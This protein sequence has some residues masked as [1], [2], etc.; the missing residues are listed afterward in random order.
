MSIK[1]R[2]LVT[3]AAGHTGA[4]AVTDLLKKGFRVRAF[5]RREDARSERLRQAGAEIFVGDL[6]DMGDIRRSLVDVQRAYY[7][8]PFAPNLLHGTMLFALAAEEARLETLALMSEWNPHPSHPAP[9][10][11]EHWI[12]NNIVRWMPTVDVTYV[13]LYDIIQLPHQENSGGR[14]YA[15]KRLFALC[16]IGPARDD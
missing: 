9:L 14:V 3:S 12:A 10:T 8:P 15:G 7:V 6:Y 1:P 11:R 16:G 2:I 5:V 4:A 13:T